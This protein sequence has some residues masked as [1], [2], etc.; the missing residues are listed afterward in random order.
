MLISSL[1]EI[2]KY[3]DII[4]ALQIDLD[5]GYEDMV[6]NLIDEDCQLEEKESVNLERAFFSK[7]RSASP[8]SE[9]DKDERGPLVAPEETAFTF[10]SSPPE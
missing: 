5:M 9:D 7:N 6:I 10:S 2:P 3:N 8:E 4:T 1:E